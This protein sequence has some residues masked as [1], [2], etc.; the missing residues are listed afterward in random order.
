MRVSFGGGLGI[1]VAANPEMEHADAVRRPAIRR[2]AKM[3][4]RNL[5]APQAY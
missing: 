2:E 4:R 5:I 1:R 3:A